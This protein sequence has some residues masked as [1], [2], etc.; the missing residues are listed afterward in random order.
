MG[1]RNDDS[2]LVVKILVT[3]ESQMLS[4]SSKIIQRQA[5]MN[6][7]DARI[8][9]AEYTKPGLW[10]NIEFSPG[11]TRSGVAQPSPRVDFFHQCVILPAQFFGDI[12]HV[13]FPHMI[14]IVGHSYQLFLRTIRIGHTQQPMLVRF[15]ITLHPSDLCESRECALGITSTHLQCDLAIY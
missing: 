8:R 5:I 9:S 15:L 1:K 14:S 10:P 12:N 13:L 3:F 4:F 2:V 6:R 7:I 11:C